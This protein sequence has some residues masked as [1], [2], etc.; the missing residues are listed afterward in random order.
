MILALTTS[1][2]L[3]HVYAALCCA[4]LQW[5]SQLLFF[6]YMNKNLAIANRS[7]VS[8]VHNMPMASMIT[9]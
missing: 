6:Y 3:T 9:P 4:M 2:P 7:R 5:Y 1:L 8:C